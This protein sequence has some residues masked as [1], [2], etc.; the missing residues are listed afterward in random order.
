MGRVDLAENLL[1]EAR[2]WMLR[3]N[4]ATGDAMSLFLLA[5]VAS[6]RRSPDALRLAE[7]TVRASEQVGNEMI[8][9]LANG[10]LGTIEWAQGD[11][12]NAEAR[13]KEA[14]RD[15][16]RTRSPMGHAQ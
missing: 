12:E 11:L 2:A 15:P 10:L 4:D 1:G 8:R 3:A 16:G 5:T 14:V 9:G 13:L 6:A 7:E